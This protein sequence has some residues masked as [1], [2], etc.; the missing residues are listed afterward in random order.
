MI[1][2]SI[3]TATLRNEDLLK[4]FADTLEHLLNT[5]LKTPDDEAYTKLVKASRQCDPDSEEA[6]SLIN[7]ELFDALDA[8]APEGY[9]FG[10]HPGDGSDFG[11]WQFEE[12]G[13][14]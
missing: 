13:E 8:F 12:E 4:A 2:G 7:E 3:S 11:F 14:N 9:Y 6:S 10:A 5:H 1:Y